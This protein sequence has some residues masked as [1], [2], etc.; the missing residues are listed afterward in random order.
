MNQVLV[1]GS[2][3]IKIRIN[4]EE[5][6]FEIYICDLVEPLRLPYDDPYDIIK[7]VEQYTTLNQDDIQRIFGVCYYD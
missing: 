3:P 4:T 7:V 2:E 1:V 5:H 6:Y